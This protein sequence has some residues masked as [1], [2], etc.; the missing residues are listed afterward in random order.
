[1]RRVAG[2]ILLMLLLIAVASCGRGRRE[3]AA[4]S[5]ARQAELR[6]SLLRARADSALRSL[7]PEQKAGLMLMPAIYTR[8]DNAT[9]SLLT[10]Y[11]RDCH[12]G[13]IVL[14]RGDTASARAIADSI[15]RM[16]RPEMLVAI[17]AEWG[18]AMRLSDAQTFPRARE[19]GRMADTLYMKHYGDAVGHQCRRLG[20]DMV[21]GPVLDVVTDSVASIMT[22][23]SFGSDPKVAARLGLAYAS[24]LWNCGIIPVAKHF[25]GHGG[26]TGDSHST[27]PVLYKSLHEMETVDLYPFRRYAEAGLPAIMAGHVAVPAI[28]P[29]QRSA[30]VSPAVMTDLLRRDLKFTGLIITDALNMGGAGGAQPWEAIAAGADMVIAPVDTDSAVRGILAALG[31][32]RLSEE[33]VDDR[34]RRILYYSYLAADRRAHR[35][36]S[37]L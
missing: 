17:D 26:V 16:G 27:L 15:D 8:N 22:R 7:T 32:G 36:E 10:H 6:D 37:R 30:A 18:L 9:L 20:I 1:M 4:P 29:E 5:A 2:T 13:G 35:S 11:A 28:D 31:D 12:A 23:R 3:T 33:A 19:L 21:L 14:L 24:S 25:P 34:C